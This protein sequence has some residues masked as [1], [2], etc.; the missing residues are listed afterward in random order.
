MGNITFPPDFLWGAATAALQIE[1]S[2]RKDGKG[3]SIWDRFMSIPG[4]SADGS[5]SDDA[6][7]HYRRYA[8]DVALMKTLW[9]RAYRFSIAWSRVFSEGSGRANPKGV[10]FYRS[11]IER[12]REAGIRPAV[13]LYHW[14]L[15]QRLQE[16]GGWVSEETTDRFAEYADFLF[17]EFGDLVDLWITHNEPWGVSFIGNWL[18]RHAPGL[19]D[20]ARRSRSRATCFFR[21]PRR[22][23]SPEDLAACRRREA[24]QHDWF[25]GPV[26]NGR[27]P[28]D[29]LNWYRDKGALPSVDFNALSPAESVDFL[30]INYYC[31][32]YVRHDPAAWP[33]ES[34]D[35]SSGKDRTDIGWEIYPE[36]LYNV[37]SWI[38]RSYPE[39]GIY[40]TENGA[41]FNDMI[42][43]Q[44]RVRDPNR[45]SYLHRHLEQARRAI[46]DGIRLKGYFA[47]SLMD[48]L[49]WNHGRAPR[50]GLVYTDY[51]AQRRIVK[52][53]GF[54]Y[55]DVIARNGLAD[56][57]A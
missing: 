28:E 20:S 4:K 31:P 41:V 47:W 18:G 1:G 21:T 45:I 40:I 34:R 15:P 16:R 36:G 13:T 33:L 57:D 17:S 30:G 51:P 49:E 56:G 52:D 44:G 27:F 43:H 10:D 26:M 55:R 38:D 25:F 37:L 23:G 2:A 54:W 29:L 19:T 39:T 3:E 32:V 9:L 11:L 53:S 24:S 7:D 5:T 46:A 42:D 14:D 22:S 12:L 35:T 6:C 48:N 50:F 8:E